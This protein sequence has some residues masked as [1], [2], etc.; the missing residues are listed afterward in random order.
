MASQQNIKCVVVG[1]GAVGNLVQF[2]SITIVCLIAFFLGK[3]CLLIVYTA[4]AFPGEY[5]PTVFD[6]YSTHVGVSFDFSSARLT[7]FT[8]SMTTEQNAQSLLVFGI[9]QDR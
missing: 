6:N 7:F 5:V 8:R 9:Q 3:T 2:L 4:N 1:D